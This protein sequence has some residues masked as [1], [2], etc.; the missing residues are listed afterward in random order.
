FVPSLATMIFGMQAG[1]LLRGDLAPGAE[2]A[3]LVLFRPAGVV[4]GETIA[5][6]GLFPLGKRVWAPPWASPSAGG[7]AVAL[8]AFYALIDWRG[9]KRW[10]LPLVVA[11][12]NPIA[13]YCLWQ[14]MWGFIR[15]SVKRHFGRHVFESLGPQFTTMLERGAVLIVLWLILL[16]MYRR[17]L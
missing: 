3:R 1:R 10:S 4:V 13:L 6:G 17:R 5:G 12:M 15:E 11:G 14:L 7:A 9:W 8:A 2:G 16:W